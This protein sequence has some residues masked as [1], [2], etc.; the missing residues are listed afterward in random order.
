M[1]YLCYTVETFPTQE[2]FD[3]Q[4]TWSGHLTIETNQYPA[5]SA[6]CHIHRIE[7]IWSEGHCRSRNQAE[8]VAVGRKRKKSL[9]SQAL[10]T[11]QKIYWLEKFWIP[12]LEQ[13][14]LQARR[15]LQKLKGES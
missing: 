7:A 12:L 10:D 15:L 11:E 5:G 9:E 14:L 8:A 1:F 6:F 13:T 3:G 4:V 2:S